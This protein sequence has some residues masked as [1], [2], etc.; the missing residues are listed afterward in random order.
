MITLSEVKEYLR[1]DHDFEDDAL[2]TMMAGALI[3][4]ADYLNQN[5]RDSMVDDE[6]P[7][8]IKSAM[9]LLVGDLYANRELQVEK[10]LYTNST[11][12]RLLNPYREMHA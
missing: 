5:P 4:T 10:Q 8:P 7:A 2:E 11:Y 9:L 12:E 1:I 6:L 3:A